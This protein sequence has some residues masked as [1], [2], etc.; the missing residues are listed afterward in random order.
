[1]PG[2]VQLIGVG[3]VLN[4]LSMAVSAL[5]ES[6]RIKTARSHQDAS[7]VPMSVFWL[8]PGLVL[9]G[10]AEAFHFPGQ[11]SL[12]Y[13]EFPESLK[14]TATAMVALFIGIAYY[15]STAIMGF[16]R[17]VTGWLPDDINHGRLDNVYWV[18]VVAGVFNFGCYLVY[19]WFYEYKDV[20]K[21]VDDG[22]S[23]DK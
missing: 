13:Q 10:F 21:V 1:V 19:A 18:L 4:I 15:L 20:E 23:S 3:H 8:V 6:K 7:I 14:S 17:R 2:L 11:V 5:A 12:Y 22:P 9:A 16:M